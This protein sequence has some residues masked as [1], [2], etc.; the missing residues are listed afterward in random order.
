MDPDTKLMLDLAKGDIS[1]FEQ[2]MNK[3][4]ELVMNIAYRFLQDRSKAEDIAQEVFIKVY[5]SAGRYKPK[6]RL[7][8]WIYRITANFCLNELR[9]QKH[10]KAISVEATGETPDSIQADPVEN[11]E[12][13]KLKHLVR[14]TVDSLPDRQRMVVILQ[15]YEGLSYQ[16]I[17]EIIGCSVSA[18]DSLLQRAKQNL[19]HKLAPFFK[20]KA[21][22]F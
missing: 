8:T 2:I 1:T 5:N 15:K 22:G 6:A 17:S 10:F 18:V 4:K 3:Y 12:K 13:A 14:E 16:E 19:K 20:N 9:S 21:E 11:L 7:S